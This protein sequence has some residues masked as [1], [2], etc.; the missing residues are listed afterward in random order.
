LRGDVVGAVKGVQE[1]YIRDTSS[2]GQLARYHFRRWDRRADGANQLVRYRRIVL[3]RVVG[4][5]VSGLEQE[6]GAPAILRDCEHWRADV[7]QNL[8]LTRWGF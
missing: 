1:I 2:F 7:I 4:E 8:G 5:N 6:I 3:A